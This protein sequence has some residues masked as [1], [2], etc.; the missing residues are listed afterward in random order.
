M[1]RFLFLDTET[2]SRADLLSR[3]GR[4]YAADPTTELLCAVAV[5]ADLGANTAHVYAWTPWPGPVAEWRSAATYSSL[6]LTWHA[7]ALSTDD[8]PA[9]VLEA[10]TNGVPVVAHNAHG[11]DRHVWEGL[12]YP[13]ATW[14]DALDRARRRGLPGR[15]EQIA[16]VLF[17]TTKD[18]A[19]RKLMLKHSIPQRRR[20]QPAGAF[21]DPAPPALT[22]ILRYCAKDALLLAAFW[23]AEQLH[24]PH[25]D[26]AVL[27]VHERID[28]RGVPVDLELAEQLA[29]VEGHIAAEAEA[30]AAQH[31]VNGT[32]LRAPP[33]L[34]LWCAE[35][36]VDLPDVTGAT[37]RG[38]LAGTL[39][40]PVRDV[41]LARLSVARVTSGKL[42]ALAART[43]PDGRQRGTLAYWGA[44]TGRWSGRGA[45]LQNFPRA[46]EK[47]DIPGLLDALLLPVP[48]AAAWVAQEATRLH[49]TSAQ[50]LGSLLRLVVAAP[51]QRFLATVDFA[52]IEARALLWQAGAHA[53]LRVYRDG[54][55]PYR[56]LAAEVF[57]VAEAKVAPHQRQVAKVMTL[58]LGY[59]GGEGA[60][61]RYAAKMGVDL[62]AT[63]MSAPELV[64][65]WRDAHP[66]V[67]GRRTGKTLEREDGTRV[68]LRKGGLWKAFNRA[69]RRAVEEGG[70]H[71][72][73]GSTW[74][75]EGPHL[76]CVLPSGRPCVYRDAAV[77]ELPSKWTPGATRRVLTYFSPR[78][79]RHGLYGG[80]LA[81]NVTQ[82]LC[83]DL[84]AA[85]LV[86]LEAAGLPVVLH[87]HD[88]VVVEVE[89]EEQLAQVREL[90]SVLPSWAT[91]LPMG[92]SGAVGERW[93]K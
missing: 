52:Q 63:G 7:C 4:I 73:A 66:E 78:G 26:D 93:G 65:A 49:T 68:V 90:A 88:E 19:G 69:A 11:F 51:D 6:Q 9:P 48:Q 58:S 2:R 42:A 53:A 84:L 77:Q 35:R 18:A 70:G 22:A 15:L 71:S 59:G 44:H 67:A 33:A 46:V 41:L 92:T 36:G 40:A 57:G 17:G 1:T 32:L 80:L 23:A 87:V 54:G 38:A 31:G 12:G 13:N 24:A 16:Q 21:I 45:Q 82:A 10:V 39:P 50:L 8:P 5:L 74:I 25:A 3:G 14:L 89:R 30:R 83:R 72:V 20:G 47:A 55:D 56:V 28:A 60:L 75:M 62:A 76:L 81:E 86:R 85:A 61:T 29:A 37:V 91:G 34:R 79:G 64:D 27:A 43:D